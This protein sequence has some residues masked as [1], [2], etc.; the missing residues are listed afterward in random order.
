MM[1]RLIRMVLTGVVALAA[2]VSLKPP[3]PAAADSPPFEQRDQPVFLIAAYYDAISRQDYA[4]AYDYWNGNAPDGATLQQFTQG[5][6]NV[7]TVRALVRLPI[8]GSVAAGTAYAEI[9]VVVLTTLKDGESQ[10]FAG[11]FRAA[12]YNVPVGDSQTVDPNWHL[13]DADLEIAD[14]VD[15]TQT[16]DA[17]STEIESFPTVYRTENRFSP[18]DLIS[19]YYDAIAAGDYTRAYG[20]WPNGAPNQT[21]AQFSAGFTNT[22]DIGVIVAL[23]FD[24]EGAAGSI[25]ASIPL[26]ITAKNNGAQQYFV[27]CMVTR[28]SNVPVGDSPIP[29]PNWSLYSANNRRVY[30]LTSALQQVWTVCPAA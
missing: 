29:D 20:Y 30:T 8:R 14:S 10:I 7:E 24:V 25:Y 16:V 19:S 13:H 27:G 17:C 28:K 4:R 15:F 12:H 9:P 2:F 5:F 18:I 26:L 3:S 1:N 6:A 22:E 21:L 23:S 11:C